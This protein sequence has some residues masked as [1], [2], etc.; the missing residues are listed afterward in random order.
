MNVFSR[1]IRNAFRNIIRTVSIVIILGLSLGLAL[2]MLIANQAV[3]AKITSVKASTG[4]TITI[5]PA[6]FRGF[7]GGG[8]P[9]TIEQLATVSTIPHVVSVDETL[10]DRLTSSDT[11]L[12]SAVD[13]GSLGQRFSE[14]SGQTFTPPPDMPER[15]TSGSGSG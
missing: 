12:E 9:L 8:E 14:R 15:T 3:N 1:G 7:G 13:A 6:G 4:N 2:A 5:S 11:S 10:T